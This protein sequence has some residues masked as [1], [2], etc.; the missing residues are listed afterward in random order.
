LFPDPVKHI[1]MAYH[2][3]KTN[4]PEIT[5]RL[6]GEGNLFNT[7]IF[8]DFLYIAIVYVSNGGRYII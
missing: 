2:L 8:S 5:K 7:W 1:E 6:P 3:Q 4:M